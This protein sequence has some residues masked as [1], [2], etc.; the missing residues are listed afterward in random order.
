MT[1]LKNLLSLSLSLS[2]THTHTQAA[3]TLLEA[4]YGTGIP[5]FLQR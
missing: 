2:H 5:E 3:S 4:K 1:P